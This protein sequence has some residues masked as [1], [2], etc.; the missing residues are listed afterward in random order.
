MKKLLLFVLI[1]STKIISAQVANQPGNLELCDD[2]ND[3]V[4][5]FDFT[6]LIPQILGSQNP[7]DYTVT[8]HATQFDAD[9]DFNPL[10]IPYCSSSTAE[11]I[12]V[13]LEDNASGGAMFDT[14]SFDILLNPLPVVTLPEDS[15]R[16]V[17]AT[18][19]L[20]NP[21]D[22]GTDFGPGYSYFWT[23]PGGSNASSPFVTVNI[24]GNYTVTVTDQNNSSNCSYS[25]SVTF[26]EE[27]LPCALSV[28]E[29][30]TSTIVMY[31]NPVQNELIL[32]MEANTQVE[33]LE[34][35]SVNGKLIHQQ[36]VI[37]GNDEVSIDVRNFTAGFYILKIQT[38]EKGTL[39]KRF[40]IE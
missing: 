17:D 3:G 25:D 4:E 22:I 20:L 14:T 23:L 11:T 37:S 6:F 35:Y 28:E 12:F 32:K 19:M 27:P 33:R 29:V 26:T 15:I 36:N 7:S 21:F 1:L 18:G 2:N 39:T 31:P 38:K 30:T 8:F 9:S 24:P 5:C 13:R 40:I 16:C 34:M 10:P